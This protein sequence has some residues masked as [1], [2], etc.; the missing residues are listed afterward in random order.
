[1]G[2]KNHFCLDI[3]IHYKKK[4]NSD[5]NEEVYKYVLWDK[6]GYYNLEFLNSLTSAI[7][8]KKK[9]NVPNNVEK[10]LEYRYGKNWKSP[11]KEWHVAVDDSSLN[12]DI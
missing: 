2:R 7:L 11:N 12:L 5:S 8:Y 6:V 9:Y 4:L 10:Y 1:M 3:I